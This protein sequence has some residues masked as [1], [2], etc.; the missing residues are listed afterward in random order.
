[1]GYIKNTLSLFRYFLWFVVVLVAYSTAIRYLGAFESC[2][3][4]HDGL[5]IMYMFSPP[6]SDHQLAWISIFHW[7]I[8][9]IIA[10]SLF[11]CSRAGMRIMWASVSVLTILICISVFYEN[12]VGIFNRIWEIRYDFLGSFSALVILALFWYFEKISIVHLLILNTA[13]ALIMLFHFLLPSP[14]GNVVIGRTI[15]FGTIA[16]LILFQYLGFIWCRT[17]DMRM[18]H[19]P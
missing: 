15:I 4:M 12:S 10:V 7:T 17:R 5:T 6:C 19:Q 3:Y 14:I 9:T 8:P 16:V 13:S 11:R 2:D 1:M 18:H